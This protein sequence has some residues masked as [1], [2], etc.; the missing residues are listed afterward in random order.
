MTFTPDTIRKHITRRSM[1]KGLGI[2]TAGG[3]LGMG[4]S[5]ALPGIRRDIAALESPELINPP[6]E[7]SVDGLLN[8]TINAQYGQF[9]LAGQDVM[10]R[11]YDGAP[12]GRTL[13]I[14]QGD[15]LRLTLVNGM[16]YDPLQELCT[17]VP[18]PEDN[19]PRGFNVTNMHVHGV[20]VSPN[21]PADN[22]LLLVGYRQT[23]HYV[24]NIEK[25]HPAGTF[26]YHAHFH[27]SVALQVASGMAGALIIEGPIDDIPEIKAAKEQILC[28]Q[29][30]RFNSA[31][32]AEN[33]EV[34]L[35]P[36]DTLI[37]GQ[38]L[39]TIRIDPG[40]VQRWRIINASHLENMDLHIAEHDFTALCYDGNPLPE[41]QITD[42]VVMVPGNRADILVKAKQPGRYAIYKDPK[43]KKENIIAWLEVSDSKVKEM[44]LFS[45]PLPGRE[46]LQPIAE[47]EVTFGRRMEFGMS[48]A[49]AGTH[50]VINGKPFSCED[51]WQIPLNAVEEWEITNQTAESHPFHI[52]VNPFQM[53]EGGGVTPGT[54]L[55]TVN[56]PPFERI[57]FRTRFKTYTG[58]FVFHCHNLTHEDI[59]MMQA[60]QVFDPCQR[61]QCLT[62]SAT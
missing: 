13:R 2:T 20:H 60:V 3:L 61:E 39:P 14:R 42:H 34:L 56:L 26:F 27:G 11:C 30:P 37:N 7:R 43:Q 21:S 15:T 33:Y 45:G 50:Y 6:E 36:G 40:E 59:G 53:I 57:R 62:G 54:W 48:G 46:H 47:N 24:Y 38:L 4:Y 19:T 17:A 28:L 41:S 16:P 18:S 58:T 5:Y 29:T 52:H 51:P 35:R 1:L 25:E 12:V 22:I 55:D 23:E 31:G 49:A 32:L 9:Q 44:P 10:L 8:V